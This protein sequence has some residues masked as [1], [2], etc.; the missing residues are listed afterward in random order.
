MFQKVTCQLTFSFRGPNA[1]GG[2][3]SLQVRHFPESCLPKGLYLAQPGQRGIVV[4]EYIV[5]QSLLRF[6]PQKF[7]P[8]VLLLIIGVR[9]IIRQDEAAA[10]FQR[11]ME[12]TV[13]PKLLFLREM[14]QGFHAD[15]GIENFFS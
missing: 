8:K 10:L 14:M 13:E 9:E 2:S 1:M 6:Q 3:P 4:I 15:S 12:P 5:S 11:G 7:L